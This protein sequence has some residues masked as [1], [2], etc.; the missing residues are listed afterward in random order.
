MPD[1]KRIQY[2]KFEK[3]G[4][5]GSQVVEQNSLDPKFQGSDPGSWGTGEDSEKPF[6]KMSRKMVPFSNTHKIQEC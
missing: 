1:T 3:G 6:C 4:L 5:G 2:L